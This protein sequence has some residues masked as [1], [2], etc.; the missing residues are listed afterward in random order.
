MTLES[1][2]SNKVQR[3]SSKDQDVT[4]KPNILK[5]LVRNYEAGLVE[6]Y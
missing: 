6:Y 4:S 2:I 1:K 5:G 3:C